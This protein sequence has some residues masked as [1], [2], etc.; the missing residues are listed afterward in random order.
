[1]SEHYLHYL[2]TYITYIAIYHTVIGVDNTFST[3]L[4]YYLAFV[5]EL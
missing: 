1:M 5:T 3:K 4:N 2:C